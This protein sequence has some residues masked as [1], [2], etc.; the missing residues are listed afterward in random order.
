MLQS[1]RPLDMTSLDRLIDAA[2][3]NDDDDDLQAIIHPDITFRYNSVNC[4]IGKRGSGKTHSV[5]RNILKLAYLDPESCFNYTQIH[6][7]TDKLRDDTVDK[8]KKL[9]P[10]HLFF[11][12]VPTTNALKNINIISRAKAE[13]ENPKCVEV[14]NASHLP[15]GTIPHT[16]VIFDDCIGLFKKDTALSKKL[17]ENRQSRITYFLLLQDVG[18]LSPS[19]KANLDSMTLFGGFPK[20]KWNVLFYQLPPTDFSYDEYAELDV[21]DAVLIDYVDNSSRVIARA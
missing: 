1:S 16:L 2:V 10:P 7:I 6:Y 14:L 20:H 12:W 4:I 21:E 13:L 9:L 19:M 18:G 8:F 5:F 3:T 15:T 11:N 17:F